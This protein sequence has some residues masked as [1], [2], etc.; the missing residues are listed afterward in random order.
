MTGTCQK[1]LSKGKLLIWGN[2]VE[3]IGVPRC[4]RGRK[5]A[6]KYLFHRL[7]RGCRGRGSPTK[8]PTLKSAGK[9][10]KATNL[11]RLLTSRAILILTLH[12]S[13]SFG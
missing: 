3:G 1:E 13:P 8:K 9:K 10:G 4:A 12:G 11:N 5:P 7:C 6:C 2:L